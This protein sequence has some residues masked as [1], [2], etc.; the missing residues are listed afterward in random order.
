MFESNDSVVHRTQFGHV[1]YADGRVE[2]VVGNS[3]VESAVVPK[4]FFRMFSS[5]QTFERLLLRF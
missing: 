2:P 4:R 5:K 3:T 1:R